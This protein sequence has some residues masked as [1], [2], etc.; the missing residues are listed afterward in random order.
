MRVL[1]VDID[2]LRPD[3]LGCYGYHRDTSPNIDSLATEGVR[4]NNVYITDAPC[5]PSRTAL[6]S[7]RNGFHTGVVGHG[8]T[9]S[10]PF[11]EGARRGHVDLFQRAGWMGLLR[12][13]KFRTVTVSS[14]AE[15]HSAWH[16]YAGFSEMY[17]LSYR[18]MEIA[19]DVNAIAL[20]WIQR[21]GAS[22]NWFLHLN[23]WDPHSPYRT[24]ES[25]G[26]PFESEPLPDW[27][28][29]EVRERCWNSYGPHGAQEPSGWGSETFYEKYPFVGGQLNSMDAVRRWIDGYDT[30]VRYADKHVG[31]VLNALAEARALDD[32]VVIISADHGENLGELNVWGDHQTADS[33]T[34]RIPLIIRWPGLSEQPAVDDAFHQHYDLAATLVE[35]V[36]E[37]VPEEWDAR[38]F[39]TTLRS[40]EPAGRDY[41]V[42]SQNAWSCQRGVRFDQYICLRTYHDGYKDLDTVMLFDL[43]QDLHEQ[44][45][46]AS[47]EP[48]T[49]NQAMR[50][51]EDWYV[52]TA[53]TSEH[54]VDPM[55]TVLREGGPVYTRGRLPRYL[56]RL[57]DTGRERHAEHLE[58][59]HPAEI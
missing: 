37:T 16:W 58:V 52:W 4:F 33:H 56:Q 10:E 46:L 21:N 11:R 42:T 8:G 53:S 35:M 27:L 54:D 22:D 28:T 31:D 36:G 23:Y 7:G 1:Y 13:R 17:N 47:A 26:N 38:S 51:M 44:R 45:N 59:V 29:E 14:F 49:V 30:G 5:L 40:G 18:G 32:T 19:D 50:L 43:S 41:L 12:G 55:M 57:R 34:C 48:G 20:D 6:W 39:A 2:S 24:P 15:R 3:H 25:F 9:A